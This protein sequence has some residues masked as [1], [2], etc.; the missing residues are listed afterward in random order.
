MLSCAIYEIVKNNYFEE[1]M[2]MTAS[3]FI[4]K[5]TPTQVFSSKFCD[6]FKKSTYEQLF[7]EHLRTAAS[8]TLVRVFPF[9]L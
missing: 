6:L 3:K 4:Q 7:K 9:T 1:H 5:L 2:R 8:K